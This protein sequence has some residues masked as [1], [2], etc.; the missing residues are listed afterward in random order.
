MRHERLGLT[1]LLL[2][3]L[4]SLGA[5]ACGGNNTTNN[6]SPDSGWV[7]QDPDMGTG[8]PDSGG[9]VDMEGS[10][11]MS[12]EVDMEPERR[13]EGDALLTEPDR[14]RDGLK[15]CEEE[16]LG[17][18]PDLA[19]TDG[20]G[21]EDFDE[22][23]KHRTDPLAADTDG[24]GL[25]DAEEVNR[26][27]TD[28]R[29]VDSD[30]DGLSDADEVNT[31]STD[32]LDVDT[33]GDGLD[34]PDELDAGSDPNEPDTD[35]DDLSDAD[36]VNTHGSDPTLADTDGDGI[37]DADEVNTHGTD[38]TS[39]DS[40]GDGLSDD[41]EI[42]DL[43]TDPA[44]ADSDM[45][46]IEDGR[47]VNETMTDPTLSDTDF[48]G[49]SDG[50]EVDTHGTD[51]FVVDTD[52][53]GLE[54]AF[55]VTRD[56]TDPLDTDSDGDGLS[57]GE[58]VYN[59]MTD[60]NAADTD[61]DGLPDAEELEY[62]LDPNKASTYDDGVQDSMRPFVQICQTG[63]S[64]PSTDYVEMA[65]DWKL[66]LPDEVTGYTSHTLA[67]SPQVS[68]T[69]TFIV[70][71][72]RAVAGFIVATSAPYAPPSTDEVVRARANLTTHDGY[73]A[74]SWVVRRNFPTAI[75]TE[76]ARNQ[77]LQEIAP[78]MYS[79][80]PSQMEGDL[81]RDVV[82][83]LI[84]IERPNT[85][86]YLATVTNEANY[87]ADELAHRLARDI[88]STE[89]VSAAMAPAVSSVCNV[90]G[91]QTTAPAAELHWVLDQSGSMQDNNNQIQQAASLYLGYLRASMLDWRV[92]V[93]NMEQGFGG[94]LRATVGWISDPGADMAFDAEIQY[95]VIDC[96]TNFGFSSCSGGNEHGL[97]VGYQGLDY[98]TS[99]TTP[100]P[101]RIRPGAAVGTIFFTD[102]EALSV[103][104]RRE[105]GGMSLPTEDDVID[106]MKMNYVGRTT[107]FSA[108]S[109]GGACGEDAR[110]YREVTYATDGLT[111]D[112]CEQ[113]AT[114]QNWFREY[115]SRLSAEA[116]P[117]VL[118]ERPIPG[119]I[120]VFVKGQEVVHGRENGFIYDAASNAL[121]F[122]GTARP[123]LADPA[124]SVPGD[125]VT[126]IYERR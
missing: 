21:L 31:H 124:N 14:D 97:Y 34:D 56:M 9:E 70:P 35:M 115:V 81:K 26:H 78:G 60:P 54:D 6:D 89:N 86:I 7:V 71:G 77:I 61:G 43:G 98:M 103:K 51:P 46:G 55:E 80:A 62:G 122:F 63:T 11:D 19:D 16:Q 84:R 110:G 65:G 66:T 102:E 96:T 64:R 83:H 68:A 67:N 15:D 113:N 111:V 12:E 22:I 10:P 47:E 5:S 121:S 107:V 48:D 88:V 91:A 30:G 75:T 74:S 99:M 41:V 57:D 79:P 114:I 8:G 87:T 100:M 90:F 125:G 105:P 18:D 72:Q 44:E 23:D 53:D 50:E 40:D 2:I 4:F 49:L 92:G 32:P 42:D 108:I 76:D 104:D 94:K 69:A 59:T 17:T 1:H 33:D 36:E 28:P 25:S 20:D 120:R 24:D 101:Q 73:T 58:E 112:L 27:Q 119:S 37:S 117:Y 118:S 109:D 93:T 126:V 39:E 106:L 95:Y 29:E 13:C 85:N 45:D 82:V 3:A 116:S 52:G 38:P 123:E